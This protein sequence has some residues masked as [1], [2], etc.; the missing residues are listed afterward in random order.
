MNG[1]AGCSVSTIGKPHEYLDP[2]GFGCGGVGLG[3]LVFLTQIPEPRKHGVHYF[4]AY[5]S[6]SRVV[7]KKRGLSLHSPGDNDISKS[8]AEPEL[9]P[10]KRTAI[11]NSWAQLIKRVYLVD[12]LKC[13][14]GGTLRVIGFITEHK[15]IRTIIDH[16]D[17]RN[18]HSRA[19]PNH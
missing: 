2:T 13:E 10:K 1:L 19:P 11:R 3:R 17:K 7:R 15:V 14:C 4:G 12:P 8:P 16:L 9:S 5:A 18:G 6:R